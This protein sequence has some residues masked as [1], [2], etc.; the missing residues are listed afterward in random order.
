L[1]VVVTVVGAAIKQA[2]D[3]RRAKI[4]QRRVAA[5]QLKTDSLEQLSQWECKDS[6]DRKQANLTDQKEQID[7][8]SVGTYYKAEIQRLQSKYDEECSRK[9]KRLEEDHNSRIQAAYARKIKH[10]KITI[11]EKAL[12]RA[13]TQLKHL[14][15]TSK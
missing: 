3:D 9:I 8:Y 6:L 13:E 1:G 15:T 12:E 14:A 4:N 5:D 7:R 11:I 2:L 10:I